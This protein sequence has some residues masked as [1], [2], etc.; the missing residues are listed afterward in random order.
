MK[1][2]MP[3][4]LKTIAISEHE[5]ALAQALQRTLGGL[6]YDIVGTAANSDEAVRN[7]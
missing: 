1:S 2:L 7:R 3:I 5:P 4:P 6:G